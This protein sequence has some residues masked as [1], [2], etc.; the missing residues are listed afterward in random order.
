MVTVLFIGA[1]L[2]VTVSAAAF[3]TIQQLH[4]GVDD[5][6]AA[7]ALGYAEAGVDRLIQYVRTSG[8]VT[9]SS[10]LNAGCPV[11]GVTR[12]VTTGGLVTNPGSAPAESLADGT[13]QAYLTVYNINSSDPTTQFPTGA[14]GIV[15]ATSVSPAD[16]HYFVIT[17]TGKAPAAKRVVQQVVK[18]SPKGL[19]IGLYSSTVNAGGTP[20]VS[21]DSMVATDKIVGREKLVFSGCDPYY[22]L[23][24]FWPAPVGFSAATPCYPMAPSAAHAAGGIFMKQNGSRPEFTGGTGTI[25]CGANANS[26]GLT[27]ITPYQSLWDGDGSAGSGSFSGTCNGLA[28]SPGTSKFTSS[29]ASRLVS[30]P[31]L[32]PEDYA[33]FK[34]AAQATGVY[35]TGPTAGSCTINGTSATAPNVWQDG[36]I[37]P[38]LSSGTKNFVAYFD[39]T[40]GSASSNTV[41]WKANVQP[42]GASGSTVCSTDPTANRSVIFVIHNGSFSLEHGA[43][44][45]GALIM[46]GTGAQFKYNGSPLFDGPIIAPNG[47][48]N[49][50]GGP[51]FQLDSCWVANMPTLLLK[52]TPVHWAEIDR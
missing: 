42:V 4:S 48:I 36:D 1:A 15:N 39:F 12:Y 16:A 32:T 34:D 21:G 38:I 43:V 17:S 47:T 23:S 45:E 2:T 13:Y 44:V 26:S 33:D 8:N 49:M 46:D 40:S 10:L 9:W 31:A 6:K 29:D 28:G 3:V 52:V 37:A 30:Q 25:N 24:D 35:C 18:I 20:S 7:T 27:G 41:F 14:C 22:K 19:P 11:S 5:R 50:G 51:T